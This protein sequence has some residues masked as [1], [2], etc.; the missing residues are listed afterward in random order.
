MST[1][2]EIEAK[3]IAAQQKI[4]KR[5]N[6]LNDIINRM[7]DETH[8]T[9]R[10]EMLQNRIRNGDKID[11]DWTEERIVVPKIDIA[12]GKTILPGSIAYKG[13]ARPFKDYQNCWLSKEEFTVRRLK[14]QI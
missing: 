11:Y 3:M 6:T 12:T 7:V 5:V 1:A 13:T 9:M 14:G 8:Q 2:K 10:Y 4:S